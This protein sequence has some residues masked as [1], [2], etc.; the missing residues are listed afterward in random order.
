MLR[1][2]R[3][4]NSRFW[5]LWDGQDLVAVVVYKKGAAELLRRLAGQAGCRRRAATSGSVTDARRPAGTGGLGGTPRANPPP[6]RRARRPACVQ[7]QCGGSTPCA[8]PSLPSP[9]PPGGDV[10]P[11]P[12]QPA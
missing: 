8:P 9:R 1:I 3:Y 12:P 2:E 11:V 10:G 4:P 5:A 7:R 6:R